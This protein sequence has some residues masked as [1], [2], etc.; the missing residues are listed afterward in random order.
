MSEFV[1]ETFV[2]KTNE[3]TFSE[4]DTLL[5]TTDWMESKCGQPYTRKAFIWR[6]EIYGHSEKT[7]AVFYVQNDGDK[8]RSNLRHMNVLYAERIIRYFPIRLIL[9]E[10]T[11]KIDRSREY[12]LFESMMEGVSQGNNPFG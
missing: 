1:C 5:L 4:G 9:T 12:G 11:F 7:V 2:G 3:K 10:K 8:H 6:K